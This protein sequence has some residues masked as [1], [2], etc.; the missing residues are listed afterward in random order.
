MDLRK[1]YLTEN[2]CYKAGRK[3]DVKGLMLHSTGANNPK[4]GR[5]VDAPE[6][7]PEVSDYHWNTHRPGGRQVCVHGFIGYLPNREIATYQTLPWN[8]RGWGGGGT[9]NN[10]HIHVEICESDLND[11]EYFHKVYKEAVELFAYLCEKFNLNP[12]EDVITHTEGNK[13]GIASNHADVMHW[14][15]K[16]G[17]DMDDFRRDVKAEM[18]GKEY[19]EP[20]SN[21]STSPVGKSILELAQE[22]IKG[23]HGSGDARRKSLGAS[24]DAVQAKVNELLGG[25]KTNNKTIDQ[26][27]KEVID[28][29]YGSGDARR[30]ALGSQ[31]DE[32][33]KR[34]NDLLAGKKAP[35]KKSVDQ[36]AKEVIDGQHGSGDAR[37][38]ALGSQYNAVQKRVNQILGSRPSSKT[39]AELAQEVIDGEHGSGR[40]RMISL[41][42]N[43]A[44]VQQEVNRRFR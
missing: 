39:I 37:R 7:E 17:K 41:G 15:P 32:V 43:Y 34:V 42:S 8:H 1:R 9:S 28:G 26:L 44:A 25:S 20:V 31:Y 38:K 30:K 2:E 24:Y 4:L 23:K 11:S 33:Q 21:S 36:L 13:L 27:A 3:I 18:N 12:L 6:L 10:T 35:V 22:V 5:Y 29:K 16:H 14:F 40:E 19:K